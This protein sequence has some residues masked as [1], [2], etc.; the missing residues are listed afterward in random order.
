MTSKSEYYFNGTFCSLRNKQTCDFYKDSTGKNVNVAVID[1]G[2]NLNLRDS[3]VKEGLGL[4]DPNDELSLKRNNNFSDKNGHGTAVTDL[5]LRIAPDVTI[6]PVKVFGKRLET[7]VNILIEA[8]LW[9]VSNEIKIINLSLGTLLPD[10][11]EPL[12]KACEIARRKGLIIISAKS[13]SETYSYPSIFENSIGV[14]TGQFENIFE[15]EYL[16]DEATE[17]IA[18]GMH[19]DLCYSTGDRIRLAGN[20]FAAP[21]I[22]GYLSLLMELKGGFELDTARIFLQEYY[23]YIMEINHGNS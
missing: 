14:E 12:Y 4:V 23:N 8:I 20:S 19:D 15:F 22:T 11:L 3:R 13:N 18:K 17:C 2:W 10:A 9:C 21:V 7:S 1:S 16:Q 6:Y 5:I